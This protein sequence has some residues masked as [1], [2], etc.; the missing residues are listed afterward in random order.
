MLINETKSIKEFR[1]IKELKEP[2]K[3]SKFNILIGKNNS[4]KT[5]ILESFF[6]SKSRKGL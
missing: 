2:L 6:I 1:G 3:L 5:A 4:G